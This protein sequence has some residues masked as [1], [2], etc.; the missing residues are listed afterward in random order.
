MANSNAPTLVAQLRS[1]LLHVIA[2]D[3][4]G[5]GFVVG[6]GGLAVT[7]AHVVGD[8]RQVEVVVDRRYYCDADVVRVDLNRD[9]A[10]LRVHYDGELPAMSLGDSAAVLPAQNVLAL[11]FPQMFHLG[12]SETIT[13][14]IVS[15]LRQINGIGYVQT[16]AALN[17]GNSGGPLIDQ[18]SGMVIGVNTFAM[19]DSENIAYALAI[20]EVKPMVA[21]AGRRRWR[22]AVPLHDGRATALSKTKSLA[23]AYVLWLFFGWLGAHRM[24]LR[25][26]KSGVAMG[27]CCVLGAAST[28][29]PVILA[30]VWLIWWVL[31]CFRLPRMKREH[32]I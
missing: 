27:A 1:S 17:S 11:G 6:E 22:P 10:L 23:V 9:L 21:S 30:V 20:D 15:A 7:N 31:D 24:Y 13:R 8:H 4:Y 19:K 29:L 26:W 28:G 14:G 3:G 12:D 32:R 16:D 5:S 18:E 25:R 2:G